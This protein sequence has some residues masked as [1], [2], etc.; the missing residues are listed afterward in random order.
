MIKMGKNRRIHV[1]I[2]EEVL[3]ELFSSLISEVTH[4]RCD[5]KV[6]VTPYA[7]QLMR[8]A[9]RCPFDLFVLLLNNIIF[10]EENQPVEA[11]LQKALRLVIQ[12]KARYRKPII[13]LY[14]YPDDPSYGRQAE[15]AGADFVFHFPCEPKLLREA[16]DACLVDAFKTK[17]LF[18]DD[19]RA[20]LDVLKASFE[21]CGDAFSVLTAED[22]IE[23]TEKLR[24]NDVSLVVTNL[25]MPGINGF[26][27][28]DHTKIHY[29]HIPVIIFSGCHDKENEETARKKG[30]AAYIKKPGRLDDLVCTVK[31]FL[32]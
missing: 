23:A 9:S 18:V 12:L 14:G 22:G 28:L 2:S 29:P 26:E 25:R 1:F 11:R 17:L 10:S 15:M 19:E 6:E 32:K 4:D 3:V 30:A 21:Q 24:K 13:C 27:L 16:V 31:R 7:E 5:L 8:L 20:L